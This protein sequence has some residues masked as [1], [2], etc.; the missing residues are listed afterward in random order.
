MLCARLALLRGSQGVQ[1]ERGGVSLCPLPVAVG[2]QEALAASPI[3]PKGDVIPTSQ[4]CREA[5]PVALFCSP[6]AWKGIGKQCL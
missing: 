5:W 1:S 2:L 4:D 3:H 6:L